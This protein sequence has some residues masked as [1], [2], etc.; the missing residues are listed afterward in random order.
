MLP[1]D[2]TRVTSLELDDGEVVSVPGALILAMPPAATRRLL[3]APG[4]APHLRDAI[5]PWADFA[6]YSIATDYITYLPFTLRW[7]RRIQL[8]RL[9]GN[10]F[11]DWGVI[12]V[13]MSD[14]FEG[15]HTLLS[16]SVVELDASSRVTGKTANETPLRGE[17]VREAARQVLEALGI[18]SGPP[19]DAI[20][21]SPAVYRTAE[22][23]W[24]T[25]DTAYVRTPSSR[26][27]PFR[28]HTVPELF[29]LG[30]HNERHDLAFTSIEAVTQ[31]A[32]RFC[33]EI[34][35]R[36]V[37]HEA[38]R[39]YRGDRIYTLNSVIGYA[40]VALGILAVVAT[41]T[42]LRCGPSLPR[43]SHAILLLG[44]GLIF[45]GLVVI[46]PPSHFEP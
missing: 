42:H 20:V 19:P 5:M 27:I 28:S 22:G 40:S 46:K 31:N 4:T 36:S 16:C 37:A 14:Y 13:A 21:L 23:Y 43:S 9:W 24:A 29:T 33:E 26:R 2:R 45:C 39:G 34:D 6:S 41:C 17:M 35:P 7:D 15:D 38:L 32:L 44:M 30:C 11:G 12:W 18:G 3:A 25:T 1:E 8:P 10:G